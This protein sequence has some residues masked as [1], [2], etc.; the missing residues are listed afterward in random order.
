[1]VCGL[2][3]VFILLYSALNRPYLEYCFQYNW[4]YFIFPSTRKI[5]IHWRESSRGHQ[6]SCALEHLVCEEI[7]RELSLFSLE[8]KRLQGNV[9]AAPSV[10][11]EREVCSSQQYMA[12]GQE[13]ELKMKQDLFRLGI[14]KIFFLMSMVQQ[15]STLPTDTV[16]YPSLEVL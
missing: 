6:D 12:G 10:Y 9:R 15:W 16:Q 3:E 4:K 8:K 11:G 13:K 2:R 7:L 14:K 5:L 1:M